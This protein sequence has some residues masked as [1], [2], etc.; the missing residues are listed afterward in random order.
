[1]LKTLPVDFT[2]RPHPEGLLKG[3]PHPVAG[4]V[5]P[6][7]RRFEE[8]VEETDLFVFDYV[9]STTF[10]EALCTDRPIVL[11]DMGAPIFDAE[12]RATLERRCRVVPVAFDDRNLP[13]LDEA[14]LRD[15]V[16]GGSDVADPGEFRSLLL[17]T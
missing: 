11:L 2:C 15:A 3:R 8:L 1:M 5:E 9:Q 14:A 7:P 13:R 17:E 4:I 10:Y 16:C 12:L 6:S